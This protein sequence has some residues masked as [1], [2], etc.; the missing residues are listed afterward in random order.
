MCT[1]LC[2]DRLVDRLDVF[3]ADRHN[4]QIGDV[5]A[6]AAVGLA[7]GIA[8]LE[9][10]RVVVIAVGHVQRDVTVVRL[11]LDGVDRA[12]VQIRRALVL[13]D[14]AGNLHTA[15]P[16]RLKHEPD[17]S[18]VVE[19]FELLVRDFGDLD[20]EGPLGEARVA[21]PALAGLLLGLRDL[22]AGAHRI[23]QT[24]ER[25]IAALLFQ[26]YRAGVGQHAAQRPAGQDER[27]VAAEFTQLRK[28]LRGTLFDGALDAFEAVHGGIGRQPVE[29]RLIN[30][31]RAARGVEH[32]H[33]RL[34]GTFGAGPQGAHEPVDLT[35]LQEFAHRGREL[36]DGAG[37]FDFLDGDGAFGALGQ[38][39]GHLGGGRVVQRRQRVENAARRLA[40]DDRPR[41]KGDPLGSI[42]RRDVRVERR[43]N[44]FLVERLRGARQVGRR[45][46]RGGNRRVG[47]RWRN[48]SVRLRLDR[49]LRP[50]GRTGQRRRTGQHG[51]LLGGGLFGG[52]RLLA[53]VPGLHLCAG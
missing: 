6:P 49:G 23:D 22:L 19:F 51:R 27:P 8:R 31:G 14:P 32:E 4:L 26:P 28:I 10:D 53:L 45:R 18:L 13:D 24:D 38:P 9:G 52:L 25:Y 47:R 44:R 11:N 3:A 16:D 34:G 40:G 36:F 39:L 35:G 41:R 46:L 33:G 43:G 7:R 48:R 1:D 2:D 50:R 42:A 30:H 17:L 37:G 15:L 29:Q 12:V 5:L 20:V 21:V